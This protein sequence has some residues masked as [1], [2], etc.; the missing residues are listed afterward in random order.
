MY[1]GE[2]ILEKACRLFDVAGATV[3]PD[4]N[5]LLIM[6]LESTSERNLDEFGNRSGRF[7][8]YGFQKYIAP[9]LRAMVSFIHDQG[10]YAE[11]YKKYGYP[12]KGE[13]N[14][15]NEAIRAG[16]GKRGK[17]S[18]LLHPEY[19][20]RLRFTA[21]RTKVPLEFAV[22]S[23]LAETENPVC[24][25]CNICLDVCPTGVLEPY[26]MIDPSHCLSYI[27]SQDANGRSILCDKCLIQCPAG[28][29]KNK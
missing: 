9:R 6:G 17:N 14:L 19:G 18:V 8:L 29:W 7:I 4:G 24:R 23:E 12:L 11:T 15:K 21:I 5:I 16:L 13:I 28:A 10:Y 2:E 27:T 22:T 1:I 26:H 3:L 20:P 25:D